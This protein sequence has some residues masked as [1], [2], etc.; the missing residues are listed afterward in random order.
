MDEELEQSAASPSAV[1]P[2]PDEAAGYAAEPCGKVDSLTTAVHKE[3]SCIECGSNTSSAVREQVPEELLRQLVG[4]LGAAAEVQNA[5][6][7]GVKAAVGPGR[8]CGPSSHSVGRFEHAHVSSDKGSGL[9]FVCEK[10]P[11]RRH[12]HM[13]RTRFRIPNASIDTMR[14]YMLNDHIVRN[15]NPGM[16]SYVRLSDPSVPAGL[17]RGLD[18]AASADRSVAT[19]SGFMYSKIKFPV[20]GARQYVACRRVWHQPAGQGFYIVSTACQQP[21]ILAQAKAL[22][23]AQ[24]LGEKAWST[25]FWAGYVVRCVNIAASTL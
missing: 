10:Q 2:H 12:L 3:L 15:S 14:T 1:T 16:L 21:A 5:Q 13:Y 25:D 6:A 8:L 20:I 11:L 23:D 18:A 22:D 24:G 4:I 17:G 7:D 9:T 19:D